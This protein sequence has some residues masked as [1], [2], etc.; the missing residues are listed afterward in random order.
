[1]NFFSNNKLIIMILLNRS[2]IFENLL[3]LPLKCFKKLLMRKVV[4]NNLYIAQ[5]FPK[6]FF[7]KKIL[8]YHFFFLQ[9]IILY[10]IIIDV[11]DV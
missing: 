9:Y 11:N 7:V 2:M 1:M 8:K 5:Y 6:I 10:V 3:Y 4:Y